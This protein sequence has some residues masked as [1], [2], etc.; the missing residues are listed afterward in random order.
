MAGWADGYVTDVVY[1]NN[2]Y[3]ECAPSWLA[4]ASLLLGHRPPDL[5]RPYRYA[6]LGCGLGF[7]A[8]TVAAS[9]PQAEVWGFD[10][11]PAHIESAR[12]LAAAAG[13]TNVHFVETSFDEL[14]T[15]RQDALPDFDI[16]V[17]H[18]VLSWIS[19][20]NRARLLD[21]IGQRL[22]PGG[23]AYISYNVSTGWGS[24]MPLR[25]LMRMLADKSPER[26]DV[27]ASGVLDFLDR[28]KAA[29]ALYFQANPGLEARLAEIRKQD[30]RYI[31]HEFLNQ[32]WHPA[33]FTEVAQAM[34]ERKCT[35][36]GSATLT[37]NIDGVS[38]PSGVQPFISDAKDIMLRETLR[39]FGSAQAFRRDLYRRGVSPMPAA[40]HGLV[41]DAMTMVWTGLTAGEQVSIG[42]PLGVLTGRPEIY[43]P[44]LAMLEAGPLMVQQARSSEA[45]AGRP[46]LDLLQAVA[47]VMAGGFAHPVLPN[48]ASDAARR[49]CAQLNQA[50]AAIN[51]TGGELPR[52]A[53]PIM[54]AAVNVDMIECL[55]VGEL[56][57]GTTADVA[58][59]APPVLASLAQCG[60]TVQRD[61]QPVS[62]ATEAR[63][64]IMD[65]LGTILDR[66]VPMLR[67]WGVLG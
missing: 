48:G 34:A 17:S 14:V 36:I 45:F 57:K 4:A 32:D 33:S 65:I 38:V 67:A 66:R 18:G 10:F 29:G 46:V 12:N 23:L 51:A 49:C 21:V 26:S 27:A 43:R 37:E 60:R 25:A 40:E 9:S 54:G 13:L 7:T 11:N 3:R 44:L 1:T 50:I 39:D 28:L 15:M 6:D 41:I 2:Y 58:A 53:V 61:G 62:N 19:L 31:A 5:T 8:L 52:I 63:S 55:V 59:L 42:T 30:P 22:K 47:L 56:I 20:E 64:I 35:Y 24:M 16:I